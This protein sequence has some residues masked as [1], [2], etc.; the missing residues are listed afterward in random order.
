VFALS[1]PN[2]FHK[3]CTGDKFIEKVSPVHYL[4]CASWQF[5]Y[6]QDARRMNERKSK[7]T[8]TVLMLVK[9]I[10]NAND[11]PDKIRAYYLGKSQDGCRCNANSGSNAK[12]G[13]YWIHCML[14]WYT[15]AYAAHSALLNIRKSR[16]RNCL[17]AGNNHHRCLHKSDHSEC[18]TTAIMHLWGFNCSLSFFLQSVTGLPFAKQLIP[19]SMIFNMWRRLRFPLNTMVVSLWLKL[20]W[21]YL[22]TTLLCGINSILDICFANG[23]PQIISREEQPGNPLPVVTVFTPPSDILRPD[24]IRMMSCE[25]GSHPILTLVGKILFFICL[26]DLFDSHREWWQCLWVWAPSK[27]DWCQGTCKSA[28]VFERISDPCMELVGTILSFSTL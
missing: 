25:D 8:A 7:L 28:C 4:L 6:P 16:F 13:E 15:F 10:F 17:V 11:Q 27:E 26:W 9:A 21:E 3:L 14:S 22:E 20:V 24:H 23:Y 12:P 18:S 5:E 2:V 1:H 19:T